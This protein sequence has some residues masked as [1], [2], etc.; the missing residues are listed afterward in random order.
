MLSLSGLEKMKS[1]SRGRQLVALALENA[2]ENKKKRGNNEYDKNEYGKRDQSQKPE[3][4]AEI[5]Q[6]ENIPTNVSQDVIHTDSSPDTVCVDSNGNAT[7]LSLEMKKTSVMDVSINWQAGDSVAYLQEDIFSETDYT[8]H[9]ESEMVHDLNES[10]TISPNE[11]DFTLYNKETDES[12]F[13]Q[14][15]SHKEED[16]NITIATSDNNISEMLMD[17]NCMP[18]DAENTILTHDLSLGVTLELP[19]ETVD[20]DSEEL[21][22]N[23]DHHHVPQHDHTPINENNGQ[24]VNVSQTVSNNSQDTDHDYISP[25]NNKA[26]KHKRKFAQAQRMRGEEYIGFKKDINGKIT[27]EVPKPA[28]GVKQRCNHTMP[29]NVTTESFQC[30]SV[31]EET[32]QKSFKIFWTCHHAMQK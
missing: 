6:K 17:L 16:E 4:S 21:P 15:Y 25:R 31:S 10:I 13:A 7:D 22:H 29:K 14:M 2:S 19:F 30:A 11:T 8:E 26:P 18:N 20:N 3:T 28:R 24:H 32:R 1:F 9:A 5:I 23:F 27:L 12:I